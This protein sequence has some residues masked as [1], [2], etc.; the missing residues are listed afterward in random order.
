MPGS[1]GAC[2]PRYMLKASFDLSGI[3]WLDSWRLKTEPALY[4]A[5][6]GQLSPIATARIPT[7]AKRVSLSGHGVASWAGATLWLGDL[8]E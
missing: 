5:I 8:A 2:H 3:A 7:K 4:T 6:W 1:H